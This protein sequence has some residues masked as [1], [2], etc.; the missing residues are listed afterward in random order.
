MTYW[1]N[2][3]Q[4]PTAQEALDEHLDQQSEAFRKLH[5]GEINYLQFVTLFEE[6]LKPFNYALEKLGLPIINNEEINEQ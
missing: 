6:G 2:T 3:I 5:A 4:P 1:L